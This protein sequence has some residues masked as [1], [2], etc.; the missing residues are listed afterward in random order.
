MTFTKA[1]LFSNNIS[2]KK[3]NTEINI[4]WEQGWSAVLTPVVDSP[5]DRTVLQLVKWIGGDG[6]Q[7]NDPTAVT[8]YVGASD[9][10]TNIVNAA[11]L[12][13]EATTAITTS[14]SNGWTGQIAYCKDAFGMCTVTGSI[15]PPIS[16]TSATVVTLPTG[17]EGY[18]L[19]TNTDL[20]TIGTLYSGVITPGVIKNLYNP[21]GSIMI[22]QLGVLRVYPET[23]ENYYYFSFTYKSQ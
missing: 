5:R 7:P 3:L 23:I 8:Y 21:N 20:I 17:Y 16:I 22:D 2:S 12:F 10:V 4:Q 14:L 11:T 19:T 18:Q 15:Q 1:D 13:T 6:V 9:F